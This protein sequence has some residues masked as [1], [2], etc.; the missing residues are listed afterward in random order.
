[1]RIVIVGQGA[2]GLLWY[3]KLV[4]KTNHQVSVK[5]SSSIAALPTQLSII[6]TEQTEHKVALTQANDHLLQRAE[7]VI[8]CV[9]AFDVCAAV[10]ALVDKLS[11]N[12]PLVLCHNGMINLE[13]ICNSA[14]KK[15]PFFTLLT[16]H[17]AKKQAAFKISH[18]GSGDCHLGLTCPQLARLNGN[19]QALERQGKTIVDQLKSTLM[20]INWCSNIKEKQWLKLMVNCVINPLT[21][22]ENI[23]NGAILSSEFDD[24]IN[25]IINEL[26]VVA[27]QEAFIFNSAELKQHILKVAQLTTHNI[28]SMRCDL[29]AQRR[30]E[31]DQINGHIVMLGQRYGIKT[32]I[33]VDLCQQISHLEKNN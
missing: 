2:I 6:D 11:I 3:A 21:A 31:I 19:I 13:E 32:P 14:K 25:A 27:K 12:V 7:I 5:C 15:H 29:L 16:T 23:E 18:S 22:I 1:M 24:I 10:N 17:G 26:L 20:N 33:N 8:F 30:S 4:Q 28:S 9:K